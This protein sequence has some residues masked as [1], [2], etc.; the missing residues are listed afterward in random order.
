[1]PMSDNMLFFN[2]LVFTML[3]TQLPQDAHLALLI[4]R[5]WVPG[6][7]PFVVAVTPEDVLDLS[8]LATTSS[9]LLELPD[10]AAQVRSC[11]ASG[12]RPRA[13]ASSLVSTTVFCR[14]W[15]SF[16]AG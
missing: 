7:G 13:M 16:S 1:M 10:A 11:L 12:S 15:V 6:L 8:A 3:P 5:L 14:A 2:Q 9:A 4:G